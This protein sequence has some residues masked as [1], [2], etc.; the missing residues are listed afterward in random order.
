MLNAQVC[1]LAISISHSFLTHFPPPCSASA[2]PC[3]Y[4]L[5]LLVKWGSPLDG[6]TRRSARPRFSFHLWSGLL[7]GNDRRVRRSALISSELLPS[8]SGCLKPALF[9]KVLNPHRVPE[10]LIYSLP[11][12]GCLNPPAVIVSILQSFS[13]TAV[14]SVHSGE[15]AF[16]CAPQDL[17]FILKGHSRDVLLDAHKARGRD[18]FKWSKAMQQKLQHSDF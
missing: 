2:Y 15:T 16:L 5:A 14:H 1:N 4:S 9:P 17:F 8:L 3:L 10:T 7:N 6:G 12:S 11:A 18:F 13:S